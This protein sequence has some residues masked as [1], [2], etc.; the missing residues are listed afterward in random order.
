M[1]LIYGMGVEICFDDYLESVVANCHESLRLYTLMD[2]DCEQ[3]QPDFFE[4]KMQ[5]VQP[6]PENKKRSEQEANKKDQNAEPPIPV[7]EIYKYAQDHVL[8]MGKAGSGKSTTLQKLL[9]VKAKEVLDKQNTLIPVLIEFRSWKTSVIDL[10]KD[11][12]RKRKL[13]LDIQTIDDLLLDGRLLLL[14]DG[15]NELPSN[16]ARNNLALFRDLNPDTAMIFTTRVLGVS[17]NL[18]IAKQM[19]MLPLSDREMRQF[20]ER[21]L[22]QQIEQMLNRLGDRLRRLGETPLLLSM[23]CDIS[24]QR[25][26]G[27]P[28]NLGSPFR[29]FAEI[30]DHKIQENIPVDDK[31]KRWVSELLQQL[32]FAMMP[33][34]DP[35]GLQQ[36]I[37]KFEAEKILVKLLYDESRDYAKQCLENLFKYHLIQVNTDQKIKFCHQSIQEYYAAEYLWRQLEDLTNEKLQKSYINYCDWKD[38]LALMLNFEDRKEQAVRVVRL[39]LDVDLG[40]GAKLAGAVEYKFQKKTI[41]MLIEEIKERKIPKLY[42]VTLLGETR[43]DLVI[44]HLTIYLKSQDFDICWNATKA[45]TKIPDSKATDILHKVLKDKN[46]HP[47]NWKIADSWIKLASYESSKFTTQPTRDNSSHVSNTNVE[48]EIVN[49]KPTESYLEDLNSANFEVRFD[50]IT[51]LGKAG[52]DKAIEPL[53]QLLQDEDSDIR[54]NVADALGK[55]GDDKAIEPLIESLKDEDDEVCWNA[56][57]ALSEIGS[58]KAIELLLQVLKSEDYS[59]SYY[60]AEALGKIGNVKAVKPLINILFDMKVNTYIKEVVVKSLGRIGGNEVIISLIQVLSD[61]RFADHDE[62]DISPNICECAVEVLITL[63]DSAPNLDILTKQLPHLRNLIS[64]EASQ[65]ALSV[66]AAIQARCKYYDY[67]IDRIILPPEDKP[68]SPTGNTYIFKEK[69]EQVFG[70]NP[71]FNRDNN[72]IQNNFNPLPSEQIMTQPNFNFHAPVGQVIAGDQTVTGDNIGTQNNYYGTDD[73]NTQE[74]ANELVEILQGIVPQISDP[75]SE[76]GKEIITAAAMEEIEN[77]P[78]LK[79]RLVAA[80]KA[81]AFEAIKKIAKNDFVEVFL[82]AFKAGLEAKPKK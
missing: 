71:T 77:K 17:R 50:A 18:G 52:N 79:E 60:A 4:L 74:L 54:W 73:P 57:N 26:D 19:E 58:D 64:T 3:S 78:T 28:A 67:D 63:T 16:E 47:F 61:D 65:Q 36:D 22:P 43:S 80:F 38:S 7:L 62:D 23:L 59:L 51:A 30:Y 25:E 81:G 44:S 32:A 6:Q 9:L 53:I 5:V 2:D 82:T 66:I 8:L 42:A 11:F 76:A 33:Q 31:Y 27:L 68:N 1:G 75:T 15:I 20:I 41:E 49:S 24:R 45:L 46:L 34:N 69:V 14:V 21:C 39:A 48:K 10:I 35:H 56:A 40:L 37:P 13:R 72:G 12:F 55:I 70:G 29:E